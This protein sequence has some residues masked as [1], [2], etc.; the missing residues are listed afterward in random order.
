M[1]RGAEVRSRPVAAPALFPP[2]PQ[3]GSLCLTRLCLGT[4]R[5]LETLPSAWKR[6]SNQRVLPTP[7][8]IARERSDR[9]A[10]KIRRAAIYLRCESVQ[11]LPLR[12]APRS[13]SLRAHSHVKVPLLSKA[14]KNPYVR[15]KVSFF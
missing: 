7:L 2:Q 6:R 15:Y 3:T 9:L 13:S 1:R 10:T 5:P 4:T 12:H 14:G 8:Y 11:T